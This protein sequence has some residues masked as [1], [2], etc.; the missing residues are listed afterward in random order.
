MPYR[1]LYSTDGNMSVTSLIR[2]CMEDNRVTCL[3]RAMCMK[4]YGWQPGPPEASAWLWWV[5]VMWVSTLH[6]W[7]KHKHRPGEST[8]HL[9][10]SP[11][12]GLSSIKMR[13]PPSWQTGKEKKQL[14]VVTRACYSPLD[15]VKQQPS[16]SLPPRVLLG[17]L[18]PLYWW[19]GFL[20][21]KF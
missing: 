14:P 19:M 6:S 21:T 7:G 17:H 11:L 10:S 8:V 18:T 2:I 15:A 16:L 3:C 20:P 4:D 13:Q 5:G 9:C 12:L 1:S